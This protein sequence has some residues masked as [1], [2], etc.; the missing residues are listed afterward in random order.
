M[1]VSAVAGAGVPYYSRRGTPRETAALNG[2]QRIWNCQAEPSVAAGFA[3]RSQACGR[4][5]WG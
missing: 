4:P 2:T 1:A 3:D 5:I